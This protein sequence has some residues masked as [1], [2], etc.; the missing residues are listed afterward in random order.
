MSVV[1]LRVPAEAEYLE[2]VRLTLYGIASKLGF[3]FEAIE[4]MKVAV[5][6]ACNNA[7]LHAYPAEAPGSMELSFELSDVALTIRVRDEG[8]GVRQESLADTRR[9]MDDMTPLGGEADFGG[10]EVGGL[11]LYLMEAL[12]DEVQVHSEP[13]GTEVMLVKY[14]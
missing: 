8:L 9:P 2:I 11:G 1:R 4:D 3:A 7:V 6:E 14:I 12:M 10:L 13:G 5:S